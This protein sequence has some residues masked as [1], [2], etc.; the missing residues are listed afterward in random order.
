MS[1]P[2]SPTK[3][4]FGD[5]AEALKASAQQRRNKE[6]KPLLVHFDVNKTIV[7]SDSIQLKTVED[8]VREGLAELFW[9]LV[10]KEDGGLTWDWDQSKPTCDRPEGELE[11]KEGHKLMSYQEYCKEVLK[12]KVARKA[13]VKSCSLVKNTKT[14]DAMDE[15]FQ[16][17]VAAMQMP[18]DMCF[19]TE[20]REAGLRGT[21]VVIIP[22][23]FHFVANMQAA[24]RPVAILFRSFG[25]DHQQIKNN[26]THGAR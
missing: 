26:G 5:V 13:A 14:K 9:G 2:S 24:G 20:A 1:A 22:A 25:V 4:Q 8:G 17:A 10:K 6:L 12:D 23:L 19:S 16:E 15:L 18:Q 3:S 21:T 7:Q 11:T